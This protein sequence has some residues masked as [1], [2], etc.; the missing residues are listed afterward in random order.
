MDNF[1]PKEEV[2]TLKQVFY[3]IM[4][5]LCIVNV[6]YSITSVD[7]DMSYFILFDVAISL[8]SAIMLDKSSKKNMIVWFLLV[9]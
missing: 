3:L 5:A 2:H 1:L 4:M 6:F 7:V 9:P 8:Y